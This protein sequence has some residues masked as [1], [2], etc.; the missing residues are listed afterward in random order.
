MGTALNGAWRFIILALAAASLASA[1][2]PLTISPTTLPLA[3]AGQDYSVIFFASGGT[4]PATFSINSQ[5]PGPLPPGLSLLSNG[6]I[7]GSPTTPG[8]YPFQ[9]D[10]NSAQPGH[11]SANLSITVVGFSTAADLGTA[12]AGS[13]YNQVLALNIPSAGASWSVTGGA[14]PPGLTLTANGAISGIATMPGSYSFTVQASVPNLPG[15]PAVTATRAF[16]LRV[17]GVAPLVFTGSVL[18]LAAAGKPFS[19]ALTATGGTGS[20]TWTALTLPPGLS[21]SSGGVLSGTPTDIGIYPLSV[22][23]TSGTV[24]T[25]PQLTF[26]GVIDIVNETP[27]PDGEVA[28][29][30]AQQMQLSFGL[31]TWSVVAGTLPSGLTL[32]DMGLLSGTPTA[33]GNFTFTVEAAVSNSA[34]ATRVRKQIAMSVKPTTPVE[35]L[36]DPLPYAGLGQ[37]YSATLRAT[38]GNGTFEWTSPS[39]PPGL[40][41]GSNGV[42]FGMPTAGGAYSVPLTATSVGSRGK[43]NL[44]L[45]V[46]QVE[47]PSALPDIHISSTYS[48]RLAVTTGAAQ[49]SLVSGLLPNG[50]TLTPQGSF[51]G[52]ATQE[53][54][55]S[56]RVRAVVAN[57]VAGAPAIVAERD[58]TVK[59]GG[60][61]LT[62]VTKSLVVGQVHGAY[63]Q[64]IQVS[65]GT[66]PYRLSASGLPDG[67]F[68]QDGA[69]LGAAEKYGNYSV[70]IVVSDAVG[71]QVSRTYPL[72]ITPLGPVAARLQIAPRL[73]QFSVAE[74][75]ELSL[76]Q[77]LTATSSTGE[78]VSFTAVAVGAPW[79]QLDAGS[80]VTPRPFGVRASSAGLKAGQYSGAIRFAS[81]GEVP[82]E[83]TVLLNVVAAAPSIEATPALVR[84]TASVGAPASFERMLVL[85]NEGGGGVIDYQMTVASRSPWITAVAAVPAVIGN[86]SASYVRVRINTQGLRVGAYRDVIHIASRAGDLDVPVTVFITPGSPGLEVSARGVRLSARER[87]GSVPQQTLFVRNTGDAG[88]TVA[89]TA[90]VI[91]GADI[92]TLAPASGE[93]RPEAPSPLVIGLRPGVTAVA[94]TKSALIRIA[95]PS[96]AQSPRYVVAVA[97]IARDLTVPAPVLAPAGLLFQM[98][99]GGGRPATQTVTLGVSNTEPVSFAASTTVSETDNWLTVAPAQGTVTTAA[100][101][102]LSVAVTPGR[103][104]PGIHFG[105]VHVAIGGELRTVDVTFVIGPAP[106]VASTGT[107]SKEIGQARVAAAC[108]ATRVALAE[109]ALGG[110]YSVPAGWPVGLSVKLADDC[111]TALASG[112]VVAHF[113]NGDAPLVLENDAL[114]GVYT[115]TW[116]PG[117]ADS[118]T[119]VRL[120]AAAPG[121][122]PVKLEFTGAVLANPALPP[123]LT[124]NGLLNNLSGALGGALA[125]GTVTQIFGD[126][127]ALY[128]TRAGAAPLPMQALGIEAL[129]GGMDAPLYYL[130]PRQ[131]TVQVPAELAPNQTYSAVLAVRDGFSLP[132]PID[133]V[134]VQPAVY[135]SDGMLMAYHADGT[136]ATSTNPAQP[137]EELVAYLVGMGATSPA[138]ASG[139]AAPRTPFAVV[140]SPAGVWVDGV[141]ATVTF[142]GLAPDQ[143][144]LYQLNF[145]V[146]AD[147]RP[148][149]VDVAIRQEG[150]EASSG[151]LAV[152]GR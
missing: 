87:Q 146:P 116:Q 82:I 66:P 14:L 131:L 89:W 78:P 19:F 124:S 107:S 54:T 111:G 39:L 112:S 2:V 24:T 113:S 100:P 28:V 115:A 7:Y 58:L 20:Y 65:G 117:A 93:A 95:D 36:I 22:T 70:T 44:A 71:D 88:S 133:V 127:L 109:T 17:T 23:I 9:L 106:T 86:G 139:K 40:S 4:F 122:A 103:L 148:G 49:W 45:I 72:E 31:P 63:A 114:T 84:F 102:Q 48:T 34:G 80:G 15:S 120:E 68:F 135:T 8:V 145:R 147:A 77:Q 136:A 38:G 47:T 53:G 101:V 142:Q 96:G 128:T 125:P 27:L 51:D 79:L 32:N 141:P 129:I 11:G 16:S 92:F 13:A 57:L 74:G 30:Y 121:L 97:D 10:V 76:P 12:N 42:F 69:F 75:G 83:V 52:V 35:I 132:E 123:V 99:S 118:Q 55:Y 56:F 1:Q 143:V 18:P 37:S 33:T 67:I 94:G 152:A 26:L 25:D 21:L 126:N 138:V 144:G 140:S 137:G 46:V 61:A 59:V 62:M 60:P 134:P 6:L 29:P 98:A 50:L 64:T 41:L 149:V 5:G 110:N 3:G 104:A 151:K 91:R 108:T 43:A 150:I 90:E 85:S 130:S 105:A 73:L 119:T 81:D